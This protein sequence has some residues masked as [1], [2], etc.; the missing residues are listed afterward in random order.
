MRP[1]FGVHVKG[2]DGLQPLVE[3][4]HLDKARRTAVRAKDL[5]PGLTILVTF[6]HGDEYKQL[7]EVK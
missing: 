1:K 3:G 2:P 6:S 4:V 5:E 7:V